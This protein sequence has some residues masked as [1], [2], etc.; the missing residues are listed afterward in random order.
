MARREIL[1]PDL[2][3]PGRP[4]TVSLWL[5]ERGAWVRAGE[6]VLELMAG[7]AVVD[8]AS[9]ADGVLVKRLVAE[10][11]TVVPGQRV[12]VIEVEE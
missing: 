3:L 12:A 5:V 8:V 1:V 2:G 7:S 6:Q 11:E 10:D 4:I 9:P